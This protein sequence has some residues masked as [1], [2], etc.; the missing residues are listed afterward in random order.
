VSVPAPPPPTPAREPPATGADPVAVTAI[1]LAVVGVL[2]GPFGIVFI[3]PAGVLGLIAF[4]MRDRRP[5]SRL[6]TVALGLS[7]VAFLVW[8]V[9]TVV[10]GRAVLGVFTAGVY[11][12]PPPEAGR[13]GAG[14]AVVWRD[15]SRQVV[16]LD[17]CRAA[18]PAPDDEHG[19]VLYAE[20]GRR[21]LSVRDDGRVRVGLRRIFPGSTSS[22]IGTMDITYDGSSVTV[23][24]GDELRIAARCVPR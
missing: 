13:G 12:D 19:Y 10:L 16:D 2:L 11:A 14:E 4:L 9:V 8:V 21:R 6:G 23:T 15:G 3:L 5:A 20:T 1:V 22:S 7:V 24:G 17:V 18:G